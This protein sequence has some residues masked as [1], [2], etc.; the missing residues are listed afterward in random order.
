MPESKK[1]ASKV[2]APP[3]R[4][5]TNIEKAQAD[6]IAEA[7]KME[8]LKKQSNVEV[9]EDS[10]VVTMGV[11][12]Y[13]RWMKE[14]FKLGSAPG[15]TP[16]FTR[17]DFP[18]FGEGPISV[19]RCYFNRVDGK[20]VILDILGDGEY[21]KEKIAQIQ[22]TVRDRGFHYAW[23]FQGEDTSLDEVFNVR[24]KAK[25][26]LKPQKSVTK[27]TNVVMITA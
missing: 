3:T 25:N 18:E 27:Q 6:S 20:N 7:A 19:S 8:S 9:S 11:D 4:G 22:A 26:D 2:V 15:Y 10:S 13:D 1:P 24:M 16:N 23:T 17:G 12:E 5:Q 14:F 21:S